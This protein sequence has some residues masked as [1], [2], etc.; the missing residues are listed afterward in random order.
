MSRHLPPEWDFSFSDRAAA[1][2]YTDT[3]D[4]LRAL[5]DTARRA[6]SIIDQMVQGTPKGIRLKMLI[7]AMSHLP[8]TLVYR[9]DEEGN[10][11]Q[12]GRI[13]VAGGYNPFYADRAILL[14]DSNLVL[15]DTE[16]GWGLSPRTTTA[17][18]VVSVQH[19]SLWPRS[20]EEVLG[21]LERVDPNDPEGCTL[22][23]ACWF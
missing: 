6:K 10:W 9:R 1:T 12:H 23:D 16:H 4:Q 14:E 21:I 18:E 13:I 20:Q 8:P 11:G 17:I 5:Q 22:I 15:V 7:Q 19:D 3:L 2:H